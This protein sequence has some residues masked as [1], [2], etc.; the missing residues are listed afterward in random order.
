MYTFLCQNPHNGAF[1]NF[2]FHKA[3]YYGQRGC[4]RLSLINQNGDVPLLENP[5]GMLG[6]VEV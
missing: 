4:L 6:V 3:E 5:R 1:I 2:I